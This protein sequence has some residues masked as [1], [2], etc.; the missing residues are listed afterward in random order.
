MKPLSLTLISFVLFISTANSQQIMVESGKSITSLS[1]DD[2]QSN[3]LGNIQPATQNYISFGYR[4]KAIKEILYVIAGTGIHSYGAKGSD[5]N[6]NFFGWEATYLSIYT[7]V[8]VKILRYQSLEF[9]LR[10]RASPEFIIQGV[11]TLNNQVFNLVGQEDFD[12]ANLFFRG[13]AMVEYGL[14]YAMSLF[15]QYKYG[16]STQLANPSLN[17]RGRL[18]FQAHDI[19]FG[20]VINL[21]SQESRKFRKKVKKSNNRGSI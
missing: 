13:G 20:I 7:G 12:K 16:V 17:N 8:E 5:N 21:D 2:F 15:V 11:Q 14:I 9:S 1:F 3:S 4:K 6:Q 19:G 10:I 18:Q